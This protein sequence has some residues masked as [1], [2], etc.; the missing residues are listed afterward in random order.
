VACAEDRRGELSADAVDAHGDQW[1]V[2]HPTSLAKPRK[3][4]LLGL[5]RGAAMGSRQP[6]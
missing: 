3:G 4:H 5:G 6:N 2:P 1:D